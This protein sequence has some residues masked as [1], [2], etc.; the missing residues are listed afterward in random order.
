MKLYAILFRFQFS[1]TYIYSGNSKTECLITIMK[2]KRS[3]KKFRKKIKRK[4]IIRNRKKKGYLF[5]TR[6]FKALI[7]DIKSAIKCPEEITLGRNPSN[8][9][10]FFNQIRSRKNISRHKGSRFI[11]I[12]LKNL[13]KID[14]ASISVLKSIFEEFNY[15]GVEIRGTYPDD[16]N[17]KDRLAEFG[18]F[19]NMVNT[20]GS[21]IIKLKTKGDHHKFE[22]SQGMIK[23][24]ELILFDQ[25]SEE[26][27][28]YLN[29]VEGYYDEMIT[30]LKEIAG[31]AVEWGDSYNKQW[32]IGVLKAEGK[33]IINIVDLGK[34]IVDSLFISQK[35]KIIDFFYLRSKLD[36]LIRAFD[37]R[38]GSF[39]Q[40]LN[41]NRGLPMIKKYYT[42]GQIKNLIVCSNE[43]YINF[44]DFS[45]NK[46]LSSNFEKF[47]GTFYQWELTS[48]E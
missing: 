13:L 28:L 32:Q 31:N 25:I 8:A 47:N 30:I 33:V 37:R 39:T 43:G 42:D 20:V 41:R 4:K 36:V 21:P 24:K 46:L 40:E 22:K 6:N 19:N 34:G 14:F 15:L 48:N 3:E 45:K 35:I 23:E 27:Y 9:L 12:S 16:I 17:C 7:Y 11:E 38:Y 10:G 18:F 5:S 44:N 26:C 29:G 2:Y 1:L